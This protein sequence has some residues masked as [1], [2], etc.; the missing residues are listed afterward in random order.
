M[1]SALPAVRLDGLGEV[2]VCGSALRR[3]P[4][5]SGSPLAAH[6]RRHLVRSRSMFNALS[7]YN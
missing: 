5:L 2:D 6:L 3:L 4:H 1:A 7:T